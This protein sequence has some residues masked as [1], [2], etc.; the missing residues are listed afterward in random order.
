[1]RKVVEIRCVKQIHVLLNIYYIHND[2][3]CVR[4]KTLANKL[5]LRFEVYCAPQFQFFTG[6]YDTR[7]A[8]RNGQGAA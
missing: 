6:K 2:L 1:M 8:T 3:N 7:P 5:W 4:S